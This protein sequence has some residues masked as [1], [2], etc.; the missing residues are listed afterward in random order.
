MLGKAMRFGA[1]L[2]LQKDKTKSSL[3][4]FP[5]KQ[6]LEFRLSSDSAALFGEVAESRLKSLADSLN[7]ELR[8]TLRK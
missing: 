2:L 8:L 3:R 5:K 4:W 6:Q 7:A 1:M